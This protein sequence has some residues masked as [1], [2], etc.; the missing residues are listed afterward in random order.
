MAAD[1]TEL[2]TY[3]TQPR[4]GSGVNIPSVPEHTNRRAWF[5]KI[6]EALGLDLGQYRSTPGAAEAGHEIMNTIKAYETRVHGP[7]GA[8]SQPG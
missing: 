2:A 8:W 6:M 5:L 1:R 4:E 3:E 7:G